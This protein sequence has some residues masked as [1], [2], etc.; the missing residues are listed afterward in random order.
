MLCGERWFGLTTA[1][2][3]QR[4]VCRLA[5]G[6][7]LGELAHAD[8]LGPGYPGEV[9]DRST[10]AWAVGQLPQPG[11]VPREVH[12]LAGIRSGKSIIAAAA[13]VRAS[14]TCDLSQLRPG[15]VPRFA[16]CSLTRDN[17]RVVSEHLLSACRH[18]PIVRRLV[19]QE[20]T[21]D[22]VYLRHPSGRPV[23]IRVVA[24]KRAGGSLVSRWLCGCAFDE[25]PRMIGQDEGV[26]NLD[27]ARKAVLERLLPGG[28]IWYVGSP[29]APLGPVYHAVRE[30]HGKPSAACL[31]IR[32]TGPAMNPMHWTPERATRA[33][34]PPPHGDPQVYL[35]D[36]LSEF[37]DLE[38]S[39]FTEDA[40]RAVT[41]IGEP[42]RAPEP[43][44]Q[45][46]AYMDPATRGNAWTLVLAGKRVDGRASVFRCEQWV[47]GVERLN[48]QQVLTQVRDACA[49]Y[50]VSHVWTDQYAGDII[51]DV[52]EQLGL[53]VLVETMS[54]TLKNQYWTALVTRVHDHT[55]E[56]PDV[57]T[58][59]DDLK[60]VRKR[61]T[62]DGSTIV[63]PHTQ[64]GRHCD[65]APAV[66]G[67]VAKC[68]LEPEVVQDEHGPR[69]TAMQLARE[70]ILRRQRGDDDEGLFGDDDMDD[71]S[72][73]EEDGA[74]L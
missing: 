36:C 63:F 13:G 7:P 2:P 68:I 25:A 39:L 23:E 12:L 50:G 74:W 33:A 51:A 53:H 5:G 69:E 43:G 46:V 29:W 11:V 67:A 34:L 52:A 31:I 59:L 41:A 62:A 70:R 28:Q 16:I 58:L 1:T 30:H 15:E 57:R 10:L 40:L 48:S 64:D 45:M 61:L 32:A 3:M 54:R 24:G 6:L 42:R 49:E 71:A 20:P 18:S 21:A 66:A 47:P 8:M 73:F 14:Q 44:V 56:L 22:T 4:A 27:D 37:A 26:V 55:V 19:T 60:R 38:A 72:L 65:F 9:Q 17:A 35:T